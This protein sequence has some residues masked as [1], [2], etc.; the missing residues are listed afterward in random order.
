MINSISWDY[1][2]KE[3]DDQLISILTNLQL[4]SDMTIFFRNLSQFKK[5]PKN[6]R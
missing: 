1:G 3:N 5:I 4:T 2:F 6:K